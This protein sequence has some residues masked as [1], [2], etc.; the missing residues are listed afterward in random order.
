MLGPAQLMRGVHPGS[1]VFNF[2]DAACLGVEPEV[3]LGIF[4]FSEALALEA[5]VEAEDTVF[6]GRELRRTGEDG[7]GGTLT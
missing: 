5:A 2:D 7:N 1:F 3:E 6:L 4:D